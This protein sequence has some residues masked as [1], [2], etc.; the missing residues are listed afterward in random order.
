MSGPRRAEE[1]ETSDGDAEKKCADHWG[2]SCISLSWQNQCPSRVEFVWGLPKE[3]ID[4]ALH[5]KY[6]HVT[7]VCCKTCMSGDICTIYPFSCADNPQMRIADG[8]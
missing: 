5:K 4:W 8:T 2:P 6:E 1:E 7:D 3:M